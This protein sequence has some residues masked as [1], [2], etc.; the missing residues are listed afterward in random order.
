MNL[1]NI[2]L[3]LFVTTFIPSGFSQTVN[4]VPDSLLTKN[5]FF[6]KN[7][8][9]EG[10]GWDLIKKEV[11]NSHIVFVG[12]QHGVAEVPVFSGKIADILQPKA[13]VV[14]I[15]P[16]TAAQLEKTAKNLAGYSDYFKRKP[17]D[18]AFYSW[19]EEMNLIHKMTLSK[20]AIWGVNEINFLSMPTFFETLAATAKQASNKKIALKKANEFAKNDFPLFG[21]SNKYSDFMAYRMKV[22]EVDSLLYDFRNESQVSQKMLRDLKTSIP[23]FANESYEARVSLM[24]KNL[25]NY[26]YPYITADEIKIPKL[27]FKLGGNHASRGSFEVSNLADNL[28]DAAGKKSLHIIVIGKQGTING[29]SPVDNS[30]AIVAYNGLEEFKEFL[31][32][33]EKVGENEWVV[34]DLR[35]IR[36]LVKQDKLKID[37]P[38]LKTYVLGYDLL[39]LIDKATGDKFVQ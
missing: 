2:L 19:Q 26:L 22:S 31:P 17:Y 1:K 12:E 33:F 15:D 35:P 34:Y 10:K 4:K 11:T 39:V 21:D 9:F 27:L 25:L 7:G 5:V 16:Y 23:I 3:A 38:K 28:A 14:E 37:N 18:F 20:I 8:N 32:F 6:Y 29:M 30:K 36:R 13:L 24:K